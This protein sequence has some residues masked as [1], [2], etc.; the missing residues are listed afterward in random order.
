M[1]SKVV[2][3][4]SR[5]TNSTRYMLSAP[6]RSQLVARCWTAQTQTRLASNS[7]PEHIVQPVRAKSEYAYPKSLLVYHAG[8]VQTATVGMIRVSTIMAFAAGCLI[9]APAVYF[10]PTS[11]NWLVPVTIALSVIPMTATYG[12]TA[13]FV[14]S[15]QLSVP[16][17]AR[18]TK[19]DLLRFART[20]PADTVLEFTTMRFMPFPKRV[21][22][23]FRDLKPVRTT[24]KLANLE[25]RPR[26][27]VLPSSPPSSLQELQKTQKQFFVRQGDQYTRSTRAPGV[28]SL[29]WD[30]IQKRS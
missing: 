17:A 28:W 15:I 22:V 20:T 2:G 27:T 8:T 23:R 24:L 11:S 16:N 13:P 29:L 4:L 5:A 12:L 18:R 6:R 7:Q 25:T 21:A 26:G 3:R 9:G 1:P 19:A 30:Q 14:A 10:D